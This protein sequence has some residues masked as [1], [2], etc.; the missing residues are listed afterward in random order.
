MPRASD[1]LREAE[2]EAVLAFAVEAA[3]EVLDECGDEIKLSEDQ[4][5]DKVFART[6]KSIDNGS[7]WGYIEADKISAVCSEVEGDVINGDIIGL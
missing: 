4:F 1:E 3:T 7:G 2:Y 5:H 6:M